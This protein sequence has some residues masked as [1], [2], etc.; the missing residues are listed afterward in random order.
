[1]SPRSEPSLSIPLDPRWRALVSPDQL[2]D[3][4]PCRFDVGDGAIEGVSLGSG[5]PMLLL[6][7]MPGW[8]EAYLALA[9]LLARRHRV[10]SFD[11]RARFFGAPSCSRLLDDVS[12]VADAVDSGP[13]L[14][15]GHSLGAALALRWAIEHPER[16]RALILSSGFARVFTP[17]GARFTRWIEQPLA[18]A[19]MRWLPDAMSRRLAGALANRNAWVF[20]PHCAP[21]LIELVRFGVRRVPIALLR[22]RIRLAFAFDARAALSRVTC[23]TLIV[24][25]ER[26]TAF[27]LAAAEELARGIAH[28]NRAVVEGAGH[29]HPASRPE[30][31][32]EIVRSW[33]EQPRLPCPRPGRST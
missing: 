18:L 21:E 26:D 13:C 17:P 10:I 15:F 1:M 19:G 8:K 33:L 12:A 9:P 14:L 6:P 30:R 25:G 23:P 11:L 2:A 5:A 7:P 16:V 29:L 22:Q 4:R 3:W 27:A 24:T 32:A 28:A 20:D 31:L